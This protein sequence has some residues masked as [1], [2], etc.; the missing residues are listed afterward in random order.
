VVSIRITGTLGNEHWR[1]LA[2]AHLRTLAPQSMNLEVRPGV[3]FVQA[4][5]IAGR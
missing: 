5:T 4:S 3:A 2:A 1:V